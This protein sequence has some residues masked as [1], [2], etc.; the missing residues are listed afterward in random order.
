MSIYR[1]SIMAITP[2]RA[3][4]LCA[5]LQ[6]IAA[7]WWV[8]EFESPNAA[9]RIAESLAQT[10]NYL[11]DFGWRLRGGESTDLSPLRMF[12]QPGEVLYQAAG[13]K[14]LPNVLWRFLHLPIVLLLVGA[15]T[16]CARHFFGTVVAGITGL[17]ASIHPFLLLHGPVWD[18][19]FTASALCWAAMGIVLKLTRTDRQR[20]AYWYWCA[21]LFGIA[22]LAAITR[23]QS[24]WIILTLASGSL[25]IPRMRSMRIPLCIAATGTL[26]FLGTWALR[27]YFISGQ[28]VI[29]STH[30]GITLWESN[31]PHALDSLA[32][33]QVSYLNEDY[34]HDQFSVTARLT[35]WEADSYFKTI[36]I[37]YVLQHPLST[38][39]AGLLKL[40]VTISGMRPELPLQDTRNLVALLV[41]TLLLSASVVATRLVD[42]KQWPIDK[43]CFA[44]FGI[45]SLAAVIVLGILGPAGWRYR[46]DIEGF[47]LIASALVLHR[48]MRALCNSSP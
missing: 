44:I 10:G 12:H 11:A 1:N 43:C 27:N 25:A 47:A 32:T 4:A 37:D 7:L 8:N 42:W 45:V 18:D 15:I 20:P 21:A 9:T 5:L 38:L 26:I 40:G 13:F 17:L 19:A 3:L 28:W 31:Y 6:V 35:E 16:W 33:G 36:A 34:M 30:D 41:N 22:G 24:S 29:G 14:L 23:L 46:M 39:Q 48:I 2:L